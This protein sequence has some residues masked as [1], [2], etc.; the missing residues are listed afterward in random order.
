[1][2]FLNTPDNGYSESQANS[3]EANGQTWDS[4]DPTYTNIWGDNMYGVGGDIGGLANTLGFE[5]AAYL[6]NS[7]ENDSA[8]MNPEFRS[9]LD[10][11]YG[12]GWQMGTNTN[13]DSR[14][15]TGGLFDSGGKQQL[16]KQ[17]MLPDNQGDFAAILNTVSPMITGGINQFNPGASFF[18][19]PLTQKIFNTALG[20]AGMSAA[21]GGNPITGAIQGAV[22]AGLPGANIPGQLGIENP[23]L[24]NIFNRAVTGGVNS[25]IGGGDA[26][27]GAVSSAAPAALGGIG[28]LFSG[29]GNMPDV[30]TLGG[31][32]PDG[33]GETSVTLG[34]ERTPNQQAANYQA[35]STG[36]VP[37]SMTSQ[38]QGGQASP[39]VAASPSI[40]GKVPGWAQ[41][42]SGI[43]GLYSAYDNMQRNRQL[44]KNLSGMFGANSSY[45][46]Q[47]RQ[48]LERQDAARGRRSDYAGRQTQLDAALAQGQMSVAPALANLGSAQ[49]QGM[50]SLFNN[51]L[52]LG[53]NQDVSDWLGG[54][55][56]G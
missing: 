33:S 3:F 19:N 20:N 30:G 43:M 17:W 11:K 29:V 49:N 22:S 6:N 31:T 46:K 50:M 12:P 16:S 26:F 2:D 51:A 39:A 24:A 15:V 21:T 55:F 42:L 54:M 10:D 41:G 40:S 53:T 35:L 25:A 44:F 18:D 28:S 5:G 36:Q 13:F 23:A 14:V 32:M 8:T 45:A 47:L 4:F 48:K 38:L 27:T 1:M 56:K 52:K 9:F 34:G 7:P 37:S